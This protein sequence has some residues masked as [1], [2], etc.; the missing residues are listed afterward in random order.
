MKVQSP[1]AAINLI[2]GLIDP[3]T[4]LIRYVGLTSRGARRPKEHGR[5]SCPDTYC[6]R[7]IR[8]LQKLGLDYEITV[9]EVLTNTD[10]LNQAERWW[11]AFG[12]ACGWPLTNLTNGGGLSEE[13]LIKKGQ[14]PQFRKAE[15]ER[16]ARRGK[17]RFKAEWKIGQ[18]ERRFHLYSIL[19]T[20]A[21]FELREAE[22][23][24]ATEAL[25]EIA[26]LMT[27][28]ETECFTLFE[29]Y[30]GTEML[31]VRVAV[32]ADVSL[33]TAECLYRRWL[34]FSY[35]RAKLALARERKA[36]GAAAT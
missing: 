25:G 8:E 26:V 30:I 29:K 12:R 1:N 4:R 17:K 31:T 36:L 18:S 6:R 16:Q 32:D 7:W 19:L 9:L 23:K 10:Q 24:Q 35:K 3:R 2:Y 15:K 14:R 28:I 27:E 21:E 20:P 33:D 34:R 13:A 5:L 11:I 22:M